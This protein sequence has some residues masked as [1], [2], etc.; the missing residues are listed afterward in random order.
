MEEKRI[1]DDVELYLASDAPVDAENKPTTEDEPTVDPISV[2]KDAP[3]VVRVGE[4]P[5]FR[6]RN[7]KRFKM[8]DGTEQEVFYASDVHVLDDEAG[9]YDDIED[10]L[11]EDEDGTHLVCGKH[12]F[13]AKFSNDE[14][15]DELFSIEQGKH[16]VTVLAKK[17]YKNKNK[18]KRPDVRKRDFDSES[19]SKIVSF[20][21]IESDSI[22]EY[23]VESTGVK[24]NIIVKGT[25]KTY[26][27]PF[28]L[29]CE[30]VKAIIDSEQKRIAFNDAETNEEVFHIPAP[31]MVD[32]NNIA[33]MAVSYE[34]VEKDNGDAV[35]TVIADSEWMNDKERA[36][37]V[38]IDPQI[39]VTNA[40]LLATYSWNSNN[41]MYSA[42]EHTVGVVATATSTD[43]SYE[44]I[45]C[46]CTVNNSMKD[47]I[48]L[49]YNRWTLGTIASANDFV[50]Y[51]FIA[52][53][54]EAHNG[55]C[56]G[57]Y[58]FYTSGSLD[59]IGYLYDASGNQIGYNDDSNGR[60]FA[61]SANLTYGETYYLKVKAWSSNTGSYKV[62]FVATDKYCCGELSSDT[63]TYTYSRHRMYLDFNYP[64]L[65]LGARIKKAELKVY[66]KR[67]SATS[68]NAQ[69]GLYH[70]NDE[71]CDYCYYE[72]SIEGS[73]I[74]YD[75]MNASGSNLCYTFDITAL[76]DGLNKGETYNN[77]FILKLID[78]TL[79][80]NNNIVLYG[81]SSAYKPEL[82]ITYEP[83]Y[84]V[85]TS[86]QA[87]S[88]TLGKFGQAAI[89]LQYGNL[90][91][92]STD[93]SWAGNRMP[94]TIKHLYNSILGSYK[95]TYNS[96]IKLYVADFSA[97]NVGYGFKLNIM[98]S[99]RLV[100]DEYIYT[101]ENG[102]ETVLTLADDCTYKNEEGDMSFDSCNLILT[103]GNEERTFDA[104]GR[105]INI[106][107]GHGNTNKINYTSGRITS[108]VDGAGRIF[109][110]NYS[111]NNLVSIVAPDG[112]SVQYTYSGNYLS[113]VTYP[114][115]SQVVISYTSNQPTSVILKDESGNSV[116]KVVY[117]FSGYKVTSATE[118][119]VENG[120]FVQG[121][122][123]TYS[124]SMASKRTT[125]TTTELE[126]D[127]DGGNVI[128]TVY[129][130][131]DDGNVISDYVYSE[132][133]GNTGVDGEASGIHPYSADGGAS[134]IR[135]NTNMLYNHT[136]ASYSTAYWEVAN[137]CCS[138]MNM[139]IT[140]L[141]DK[142]RRFAMVIDATD[143]TVANNTVYQ[144]TVSLAAGEYTFSAYVR[145]ARKFIGDNHGAF[146]R[147]S[148]SGGTVL[149][150]SE[151]LTNTNSQYIRLIA[152]F[153]IDYTQ[154]V[155]VEF[156]LDG[157]GLVYVCA[158][159]LENNPF[160]NNY[161]MLQNGNFEMSYSYWA[162][163]SSN[164]SVSTSTRFNLNRSMY[165]IGDVN[166]TRYC[167]QIIYP[168]YD[169]SVRETFTLSGWAKGYGLPMHERNGSRVPTFRLRAKICYSDGTTETHMA[170]FSSCTEEWQFTSLQFSKEKFKYVSYIY[171]YCD[172]DYN[173][174]YAYFDDIQLVRNSIE[175]G[176]TAND[177]VVEPEDDTDYEDTDTSEATDS[178]ES[179]GFAE[180]IDAFGNTITETTFTDGE[181]GTIYRAFGFNTDDAE[182]DGDNAGNDMV[183]ETDARGNKTKYTV[184]AD[185]S[186]NEEVTDRCGN[187]TA[188][189]YDDAGRTTKVTS[190]NAD[191]AEIAHVSYAYD[192]FDNMTEIA[193]GDG[194]K[195]ALKYNAFHNLESIGIDGK[196]EKLIKYAYKNGNGRLKQMTYANG[197]TM[198]AVY[199][200]IGQ[201]V[202]EKWFESEAAAA[203]STATPISHYK[204]VYDSDG[205]IVRSIDISGK[206]EYNYEYEEGKIVRATEA[207]IELSGEIVTSKVIVNTVKYYYDTEG[208]MTK[209]VITPANGSAQTIYYET[210]D[211]NTV[212]KFSAG[213]R[214]VTSHSKT[215][216]FGR[217]VFDELQLGTDFV[218]RQFVYHAGKVTA[219]HKEKA[220]VKSSATTQLVSQIILSD[221][222]TLSYEYDAEERITSI[223]EKYTVDKVETT[224][225]TSYTY[226]ALGQLLTETN[227]V[228]TIDRSEEEPVVTVT[229][230]LVNSME[231]DNYGNITKKNGKV[232]TY[233]N[234]KWKDLLTSYNGQS[235][236]Y[237]AQGNPTSYLGHTMTWGKG[238]QLKKFDNIEYTYNANGIRTSKKV[239]DVL[240]TYTLDGTKILR[241]TWGSNTLIP[242]Y[243]N[244]DGVCGILYN[245][246]P[247][248][249]IK[250]LQGDV[251]AIVD[252]D[253]QTVAR[254][255]YDAWGVP[256]VKLD[257][258]DCQIATIN[259]FRYR[260]YY[261]DEETS[262]YYLQ[263]RYYDAT[264]GR[265]VNFDSPDIVLYARSSIGTNIFVYCSNDCINNMD[266][267][268]Y[269]S[270]RDIWGLIKTSF[271]FIRSILEQVM[272][273][274]NSTPNASQI[275][276]LAKQSGKSQRQ[277][278]K[279]LSKNAKESE[280]CLKWFKKAAK[281]A[282][283]ISVVLF[284]IH[285]I[286]LGKKVFYD[287]YALIVEIF[288]EVAGYVIGE[289]FSAVLK[290]VPYA[291]LI[292]GVAASWVIGLAISSHFTTNNKK[293]MTQAYASKMKS[294]TRWYDWML[295]L[296]NSIGATF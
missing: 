281:I 66:R 200:S 205:N 10:T 102:A 267:I 130:F 103:I 121:S 171:I 216:S 92:D 118:Y 70:I 22:Y 123:S 167:G 143:S 285:L 58:T 52:D 9:R 127:C 286:Q 153:E 208:K 28:I 6:E 115:G 76:I 43:T 20:S 69:L 56:I 251:I 54:D 244:E 16:K 62:S 88:H 265:F 175:T 219:E 292:L 79:T 261:Y 190:K 33:S 4:V 104:S 149:A 93:F 155:K 273:S 45:D 296:F 29:K 161:N 87:H 172:Y 65:S 44:D 275:K 47:A 124:Y 162:Y 228:Q 73:L 13:I 204:Y 231:Y 37:P 1:N 241:E 213:G 168:I 150:V 18:G 75:A 180:V 268:G 109:E 89:D 144:N 50:W 138:S 57:N 201:M 60:N 185:T 284:A 152:P 262:L 263:S 209:K 176:V 116:Y 274:F 215:D 78:E 186:R 74:D 142:F 264:A 243:D 210:N 64:S 288:V 110:F 260:G 203:S 85:N 114:D 253:A 48:D 24:E 128:K 80:S 147:V 99:M 137:E 191:G 282:K 63:P 198:K 280:K 131:D 199:N 81:A 108:V 255:S 120:T 170:D 195:Y 106:K 25:K 235:I 221:G 211:D 8:S 188:Y 125:V 184:D 95:H 257:S 42:S 247:Y 140:S 229:S 126:D 230:K 159:Q 97:M 11:T 36:F 169:R 272:K 214:T 61:I 77:K 23:T 225:T 248:Y 129:T 119:G 136:F 35:L 96:G 98:Q 38:V 139:Y 164:C 49:T 156:V 135:N 245:N 270:F 182:M 146:I 160:A 283:I 217:K 34:L 46:S 240:H 237:D 134:I 294:S 259:P 90:T 39:K 154:S 148:T 112:T 189:E 72:P 166:S 187:K 173:S 194:M 157:D 2:I 239:N 192:A 254:Y 113:T 117:A 83:N 105:L 287:I 234:S 177:F 68:A 86:Y 181:F 100:G 295:G 51:K 202:A 277:V 94:V 41:Y 71:I 258:S 226:D 291:G 21:E 91:F 15:N 266:L 17:N 246:V 84:A 32:N 183:S 82:V 163:R 293:K 31:F 269:V 233:G 224:D 165:M 222:R 158:P 271:D 256:E 27:Y 7:K 59:T 101:D 26:R 206:K 289:I 133:T 179:A 249:F 30:N 290:L 238:R 122:K 145:V 242:L 40:T 12:C 218:S 107:D 223:T 174:G 252:K 236:T 197:H 5:E 232:Y 67:N 19:E 279:E 207:D 14:K 227:V 276:K 132:D 178:T 212:V 278:I 220:K 53:V 111:G 55:E 3:K 250:N 193:R 196:A 141:S 151:K